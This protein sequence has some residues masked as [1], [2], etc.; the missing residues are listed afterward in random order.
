MVTA[1]DFFAIENPRNETDNRQ[2]RLIPLEPSDLYYMCIKDQFDRHWEHVGRMR[3]RVRAIYKVLYLQSELQPFLDYKADVAAA[4]NGLVVRSLFHGTTRACRLGEGSH[5][6][7]FCELSDCSLCS[8]IRNSF[9]VAMCGRK[10]KFSRF[11]VGIY[12]TPC[13]SKADDY[14]KNLSPDA[15]WRVSLLSRVVVGKP[16][17]FR[18]NRTTLTEPPHG[19]DSVWGVPGADLNYEETVVYDNNAIR[20]AYLVVYG[21]ADLELDLGP[22]VP[23]TSIEIIRRIFASAFV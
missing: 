12:T 5:N 19:F 10:N 3:P 16:K 15:K 22:K 20:P 23:A 4:R 6:L 8:I 7:V 11:G 14:V 13:S 2:G 17:K 1:L 21:D 9:D 18:H